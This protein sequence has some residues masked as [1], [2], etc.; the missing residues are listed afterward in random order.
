[1]T[2][3]IIDTANMFWKARHAYKGN[4]ND[5]VGMS[6]YIIFNSIRK[7]WREFNGTHAVFAF[8]GRSWRKDY[9][10]L[11]KANRKIDQTSLSVQQIE[12]EKL[13]W[14]VFEEFKNFIIEKTNCTV[15]HHPNLEA[16]DLIA[17]W[18]QH[19]PNDQHVI[20]SSDGDFA[21]L[22]N[23]NVVQFNGI[24]N[25]TTTANG[26]FDE[27]NKPVID[28]KT[29]KPK[30]PPDPEWLLFLKCIRGDTSDNV[31]SAYP[32]VRIKGSKN[33]VGLI[34][35]Y[36][37]RK[38]KGYNW[39]NLMLQ[40]WVDHKG[41]EHQVV[42]DYQRNVVLCDLTAQPPHVKE[43]INE[44]ITY[45]SSNPKNLSQ[46]GIR[47]LKFCSSYDLARVI[48]NIESYSEP[49]SARYCKQKELINEQTT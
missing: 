2:Y 22:I 30:P 18:V 25:I 43:F 27:R 36:N 41:I 1:M 9:Y 46:V 37:D 5:K 13:F 8:E 3:I 44:T 23:E 45:S 4:S 38:A 10:P 42:D 47:I 24:S 26:Y 17:G 33:K 32:G 21:Q 19:H 7:V 15:L 14:E 16:D 6:L 29:K 49:F 20:V 40:R 28:N 39:N 12:E 35:A 48:E 34:D 11:Y 31:F